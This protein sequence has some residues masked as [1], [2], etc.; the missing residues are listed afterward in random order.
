MRSD[1]LASLVQEGQRIP[2]WNPDPANREVAFGQDEVKRIIPHRDPFLF[3]DEIAGVNLVHQSIRG[4]RTISPHDPV[5]RGHI[6]EEPIY[7]GVL[8]I[9]TM[10]QLA[11]CL[12]YFRAV[13]GA[14]ISAEVRLEKL[15]A[16]RIHHGLILNAVLPGDRLEIHARLLDDDDLVVTFEG[17]ILKDGRICSYGVLEL[18]YVNR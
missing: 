17:Q 2:L 15:L 14:R 5:F 18:I 1:E 7:P 12:V 11:L 13:G 3:V 16:F 4:F 8:H 9:E 6:P 10:G